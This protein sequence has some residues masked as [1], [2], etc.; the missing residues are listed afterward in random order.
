MKA[1]VSFPTCLTA[2]LF[3]N[4][5]L[6]QDAQLPQ[7]GPDQL[8]F[9]V[10]NMDISADPAADFHRYAA[11]GW[12]DRVE[13]PADLASISAFHYMDEQLK[14]QM[15]AAVA[16][17]GKEAEQAPEGS[18]AKLIGTFYNAYMDIDTRNAAGI[19]PIRNELD[20]I[21]DIGTFDDLIRYVAHLGLT[22][23][24]LPL[25]GMGPS[26]DLADSS[27]YALYA[28][29]GSLSLDDKTRGLLGDPDD[30]ERK[31]AYLHYIESV[32]RVAGYEAE[33][34]A[35]ISRTILDL[36]SE[37]YG[38]L[39]TKAE[40]VDPRSF[41][42]PKT[43]GEL[44]QQIPELDLELFLDE[45]GFEVPDR[46]ILTE[47]R[48]FNVLSKVLQEHPMEDIRDYLAFRVIN[49]YQDV[50]TT[51]FEE[52]ARERA[53]LLT[54]VD[55]LRPRE[56]RF[57]A[58]AEA[59]FGQLLGKLYVDHFFD[60]DTREKALDM[61]RR[62][63]AAFISRLP[64]REWLSEATR[65]DALEKAEKL[66][67][68][69]GYPKEWIDYGGV[70]IGAS[71]AANMMNLAAFSF[72]R[73]REKFGGPVSTEPF[74][75]SSTYP[76]VINAG[77]SPQINGFEVPAAMLQPPAFE[78]DLDASVYF[79]RLGAIIGHEMTHGF[80][81]GGRQYDASGSLRNWWT[82]DAEVAFEGEAQ[83][84]VEQADAFEALPGLHVVG[85]Q[86]V[87]ENMADVGGVN[88]AHDALMTY[89]EEHPE[90]NIEI[91]GLTP[92][93]RCFIAWAQLWTEKKTEA[94][95]RN[96][97][98]NDYHAPSN[99]RAV[100]PL[101]HVDAFYEAFG[102][103]EGDPMWLPSEKRVNAW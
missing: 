1:F 37:L 13:R 8:A 59:N 41:Y 76:T 7:I 96:Q 103:G 65:A 90:Q 101:R 20:R 48:Y 69:A 55:T 71:P 57:L 75:G 66:S 54:G 91:D 36:E 50:L 35:S 21:D 29:G 34:A 31:Q 85:A 72:A 19:E 12:L 44:Q 100:A 80:D 67:Y 52:P 45:I 39:L 78:F 62:I 2:V 99:Y 53:K 56:D 97:V 5:T 15:K 61:M 23:G 18:A 26:P 38:G 49:H 17:A 73:E 86:T 3:A 64:S 11:G 88:L 30:S 98:T 102:I 63:K 25:L 22:A 33:P 87:K 68:K 43:L 74:N 14:T 40:K 16:S 83:K 84:L 46:I 77:Y 27:R 4:V 89:L 28:V 93:Q 82:P 47:P 94:A 60:E 58:I 70:E 81:S 10:E 79:C 24:V 9:S 95:L 92:S 51:A 42:N 32:L 6:A